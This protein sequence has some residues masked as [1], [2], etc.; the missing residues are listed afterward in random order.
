MIVIVWT[1]IVLSSSWVVRQ[2][3][4]KAIGGALENI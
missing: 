1:T 4:D 2:W 3:I